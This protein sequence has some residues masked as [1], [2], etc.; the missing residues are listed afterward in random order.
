MYRNRDFE[1]VKSLIYL[2]KD[3]IFSFLLIIGSMTI[4][5]SINDVANTEA[6]RLE[7]SYIYRYAFI[8]FLLLYFYGK[9]VFSK[10]LL[11]LLILVSFGIQALD[12]LYQIF[13][14]YDLF[15]H[16]MGDLTIGLQE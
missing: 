8:L 5:N 11:V 9:E 7:F 4:S 1:Y 6:W 14:G 2:Y 15:K 12:G 10:K 13:M 16:N 3:I